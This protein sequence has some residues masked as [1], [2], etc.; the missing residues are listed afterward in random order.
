MAYPPKGRQAREKPPATK[1][2]AC[3]DGARCIST[4]V[5]GC[6]LM[7]PTKSLPA[8]RPTREARQGL[9]WWCELLPVSPHQGLDVN[10]RLGVGGSTAPLFAVQAPENPRTASGDLFTFLF[11]LSSSAAAPASVPL[12]SPVGRTLA[13]CLSLIHESYHPH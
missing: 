2:E 3:R 5:H 8:Y 1:A 11:L 6:S 12:R 10:P 13:R 4:G 9:A 7:S